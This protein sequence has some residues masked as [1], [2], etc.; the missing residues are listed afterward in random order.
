M[1]YCPNCG[2]PLPDGAKFCGSCG[3]PAS[4]A[5]SNA[6][7]APTYSSASNEPAY[8]QTYTNPQPTQSAYTAPTRPI[9]SSA[10]VEPYNTT[11]LW[12]WSIVTILLSLIPGV[13]AIS[14]TR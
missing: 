10:S 12:I 4:A 11:G 3:S 8:S 1:P 2:A 9:F 14:L 5:S 6:S 13:V 7:G